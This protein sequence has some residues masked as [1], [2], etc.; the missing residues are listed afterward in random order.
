VWIVVVTEIWKPRNKVIFKG[1][2]VD[3]E[4]AL[5]LVQLKSWEWIKHRIVRSTFSYSD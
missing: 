2:K 4:E 5:C 3:E 1:G